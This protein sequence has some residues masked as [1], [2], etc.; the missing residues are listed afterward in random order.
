VSH[1][2][3]RRQRKL[4]AEAMQQR[5]ADARGDDSASGRG[6]SA[7]GA[8]HPVLHVFECNSQMCWMSAPCCGFAC[9]FPIL[10]LQAL[11]F[12]STRLRLRFLLLLLLLLCAPS[13]G[14]GP[15]GRGIRCCGH[16]G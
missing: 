7:C 16:R 14:K 6:A 1:N 11:R 2:C 3:R 5:V 8:P 13:S 12:L 15:A 10:G 9:V 4:L